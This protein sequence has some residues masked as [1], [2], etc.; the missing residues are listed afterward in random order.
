MLSN[1]DAATTATSVNFILKVCL[2]FIILKK[3][4]NQKAGKI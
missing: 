1:L 4:I 2:L 3:M